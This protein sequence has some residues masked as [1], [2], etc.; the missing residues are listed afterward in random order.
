M[1]LFLIGR[2]IRKEFLTKQRDMSAKLMHGTG[3]TLYLQLVKVHEFFCPH[4]RICYKC[5]KQPQEKEMSRSN[6][7]AALRH[8]KPNWQTQ[9]FTG[10]TNIT[11]SI[12]AWCGL[13]VRK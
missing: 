13:H 4:S 7:I 11:F 9:V 5:S 2:Y 10:D 8:T 3:P 1:S 12:T 6:A